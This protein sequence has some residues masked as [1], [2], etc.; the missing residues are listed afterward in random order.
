MDSILN[1]TKKLSG[2]TSD[3]GHYDPDII[4]YINNV[5][6]TLKQLGVGPSKG[7]FIT[8]EYETWNDFITDDPLLREATKGYMGAKVRL[9][10][11][12]PTSSVHMEALK[13]NIKEYEWRLNNEV[14]TS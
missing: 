8:G 6:L 14:E 13:E 7:F 5:L 4:M 11:D 3:Y 1:S 12:P 9:Q 2:L 10:F